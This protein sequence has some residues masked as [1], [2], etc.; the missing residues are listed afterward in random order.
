MSTLQSIQQDAITL[1][2]KMIAT[3]SFSKEE[4]EVADLIERFLQEKSIPTKRLMHNIY[5]FNKYFDS[6]KPSIL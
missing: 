2:K 1:L 6:S 4:K 5:A 3:P